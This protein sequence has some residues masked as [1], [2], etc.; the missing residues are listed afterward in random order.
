MMAGRHSIMATVL[1][2]LTL[3]AGQV[4]AQSLKPEDFA[5]GMTLAVDGS[6]ALYRALPIPIALTPGTRQAPMFSQWTLTLTLHED[7]DDNNN[8][9]LDSTRVATEA[10]ADVREADKTR[11]ALSPLNLTTISSTIII[12][13][14]CKTV[15]A[16]AKLKLTKNLVEAVMI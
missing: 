3:L 16:N 12:I 15:I 9:D 1:L 4:A 14:S 6:S 7:N 5:Y 13:F 11:L 10:A 2:A 8:D